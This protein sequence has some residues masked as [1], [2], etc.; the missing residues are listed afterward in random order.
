MK[1]ELN[2]F[3][4]LYANSTDSL[5]QLIALSQLNNL[6]DDEYTLSQFA[7]EAELAGRDELS[8][9]ARG[10]RDLEFFEWFVDCLEKSDWDYSIEVFEDSGRL[11]KRYVK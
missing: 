11:L 4:H 10:N 6:G 5:T 3:L 2:A 9:S 1:Y 7:W 8:G